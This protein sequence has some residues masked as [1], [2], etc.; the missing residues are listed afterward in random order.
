[1]R[2]SQV[3]VISIAGPLNLRRRVRSSAVHLS[4]AGGDAPH[5]PTWLHLARPASSTHR[6]VWS[7]SWS[8]QQSSSSPVGIYPVT[9]RA[10]SC[11]A[12]R[13]RASCLAR[14]GRVARRC[15]VVRGQG[16]QGEQEPLRAQSVG[17]EL[18][19]TPTHRGGPP[20][21][22]PASRPASRRP[23]RGAGKGREGQ[24]ARADGT[25]RLLSFEAQAG[26]QCSQ[27]G[28]G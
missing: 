19:S 11:R 21:R 7:Q 6:H 14:P 22:Q 3:N 4:A 15:A 10:E 25:G 5:P 23:A 12:E 17:H 28:G 1:M 24:D 18:N 26:R 8:Q 20:V 16:E 27:A 13:G 9:D 2:E